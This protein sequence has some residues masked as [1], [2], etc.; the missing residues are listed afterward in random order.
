MAF[1]CSRFVRHRID[2]GLELHFLV[3]RQT[4]NPFFY[5]IFVKI[6]FAFVYIKAWEIFHRIFV[7]RFVQLLLGEFD[8]VMCNHWT[9]CHRMITFLLKLR[10]WRT[11]VLT[12]LFCRSI[13]EWKMFDIIETTNNEEVGG[14]DSIWWNF[15][16]SIDD[17]EFSIPENFN[18]CPCIESK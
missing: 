15:P 7:E 4:I 17:V 3:D 9:T 1:V 8:F 11:I 16:F 13:K 2:F 6:V 14:D 5:C 12:N 18:P 10:L